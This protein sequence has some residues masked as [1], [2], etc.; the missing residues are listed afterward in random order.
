M[1][2]DWQLMEQPI[3]LQEFEDL[4]LLRSTFFHFGL[5]LEGEAEANNHLHCGAMTLG[6]TTLSIKGLHVTLSISDTQLNNAL[7]LC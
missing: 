4:P 6:P 3:S 1:A 2:P 5:G 7:Q